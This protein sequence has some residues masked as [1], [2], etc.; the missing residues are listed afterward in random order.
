M[1]KQSFIQPHILSLSLGSLDKLTQSKI[2]ESI[3]FLKTKCMQEQ[4]S[5]FGIKI[6]I[7]HNLYASLH[8][9]HNFHN[10]CTALKGPLYLHL[11][12]MKEYL[13]S[14]ATV[15]TLSIVMDSIPYIWDGSMHTSTGAGVGQSKT[16]VKCTFQKRVGAQVKLMGK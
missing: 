10:T 1:T 12:H 13:Q 11:G 16:S 4:S 6:S 9:I 2:C 15:N 5:Q 8:K 3:I 14:H 7:P